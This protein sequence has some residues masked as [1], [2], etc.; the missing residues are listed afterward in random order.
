MRNFGIK[1]KRYILA[2]PLL[3]A[4]ISVVWTLKFTDVTSVR[5]RPSDTRIANPLMGWAV[6][7][8]DEIDEVEIDHSLVYASITWRELEVEPGVYDFEAFEKK[9]NLERWW[10]LGKRVVLRFMMDA[11]GE[12]YHMDIPD[13]L[14]E[15]M[16]DGAGVYYSNSLGKGFSP[17]YTNMILL[18]AHRQV[19]NAVAQ[20]YDGHFGI[21]F[22]EIGSVGHFGSWTTR[23]VDAE[24][25]MPPS[26]DIS[27]WIGHY[28][29]A[30]Q[31]TKLLANKAYQSVRVIGMGFYNDL[32]GNQS[33]TWDWIDTL[34]YGGFD[35]QT[36]A[37]LRAVPEAME[38]T[39]SGARIDTQ[40]P[41]DRL[42]TLG[43]DS[44][45][46]QIGYCHTTYVS[47]IQSSGLDEQIKSAMAVALD[48]MG[49]R[50][51]I[52][53][54]AWPSAIRKGYTLCINASFRNDGEQCFSYD[55]PMEIALMRAENIVFKQTV[56]LDVQ[57]LLPGQTKTSLFIDIPTELDAG[58]YSIA[59][60]ILDPAT[61]E[62][63]VDF[64]MDADEMG[65]R[66]ILG[67]IVLFD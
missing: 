43:L 10:A 26:E 6:E 36:S 3:L 63:A 18:N 33:A 12:E 14:Y 34:E 4:L 49:Y 30:F 5:F 66:T 29:R 32:L 16:G 7:A 44:L 39:L 51:W 24:W 1:K 53:E 2:I 17:N 59:I 48:N 40:V 28:A 11:P 54:A 65:L 64:A 56:D 8:T 42:F 27:A 20:R 46:K 22:V 23:D 21:A 41:F 9:N 19:I 52:R 60:A 31:T 50:L 38:T 45:V 67:D 58:I 35:E 55:W 37:E 25:S 13:W 15:S 62:P 61:G 57:T 47:G